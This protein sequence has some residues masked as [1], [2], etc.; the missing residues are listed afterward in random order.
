MI[1][2]NESKPLGLIKKERKQLVDFLHTLTGTI[3]AD[4]KWLTRP[5]NQHPPLV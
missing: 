4:S 3:A 1:G 2:H 5:K